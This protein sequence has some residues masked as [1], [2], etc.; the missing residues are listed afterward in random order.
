MRRSGFALFVLAA[1]TSCG[2]AGYDSRWGQSAAVQRQHAA[3]NA[4]T[5]HGDRAADAPAGAPANVRTLKVRAVVAKAYTTQVADVPGTLREL[6]AD[7]ND[8]T[9]PSL[10]VKLTLDGIQSWEVTKDDDL[11]KL[12]ATLR[13]TEPGTDVDW[14]A[15]FVGSL[16]RMTMSFHDLGIGDLPGRYVVL[17]APS[18]A[19]DH[20]ATERAYAELKDDERRKVQKEHRRHRVAAVFLHEI[21][22]T[23][24]ALHERSEKNLM[25]PEYR[26]KMTTFGPETTAIMRN[27]LAKRDAKAPA[28]QAAM[29]RE[30]A[31]GVRSAAPNVFF[32]QEKQQLLTQ[33]DDRAERLE[34]YTRATAAA[35]KPAAAPAAPPPAAPPPELSA[36]D[37]KRFAEANERLAKSDFTGAW[38]TAKPLFAAYP[39]SMGVQDMR[40]TLA[41]KVFA[42]AAA[43][44][45]CQPLMKLATDAK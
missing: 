29:F 3:D 32:D 17:R 39:K 27:V 45:E 19:Q 11:P 4:P 31:A 26:A 20:D 44:V 34:G 25:F 33:L 2:F 35:A 24:G 6:F 42:F 41:T 1:T 18:S 36:D 37:Q 21:G 7:V 30:I 28:D 23:L 13:E 16:S 5:L 14:V 38:E 43:R 40:C 15:G 22:H 10:G 8:V 9:E 12:L